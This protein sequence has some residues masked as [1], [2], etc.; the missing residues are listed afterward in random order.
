VADPGTAETEVAGPEL[1]SGGEPAVLSRIVTDATARLL[2]GADA[3]LTVTELG[4]GDYLADDGSN[5]VGPVVD[6]AQT[7]PMLGAYR[8]IVARRLGVITDTD[9]LRPLIDYLAEPLETTRLLLVWE[10]GSAQSQLRQVPAALT[11]AVQAAGGICHHAEVPRARAGR[12]WLVEQLEGAQV[13]LDRA[14]TGLLTEHLGEDRSR[15]WAILDVL[16][17]AYG[18]GATLGAD[19]VAPFL[20][21]RGTVPPWELT[22]AISS[23]DITA[24]LG[25]LGR[26]CGPEAM[27]PMQ[28]MATLRNH[29]DR[30]LHLEG[31]GVR[32]EAGAAEVL[33]GAGLLGQRAATFGARKALAASRRLGPER[34]RRVVALLAA[35]DLDLRGATALA[36]ETVLEVLVARL[37]QLHRN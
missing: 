32:D 6:A 11:R 15:V 21:E 37:G 28:V 34:V 25:C 26:L 20:G 13:R 19:E 8:V 4:E 2:G 14:A 12:T 17:G 16:A 24:A 18:S 1:V 7:P 35:A 3:T 31:A 9:A 33:R 30:I 10:R 23:G 5:S 29:F 36:P 22:D 27:H